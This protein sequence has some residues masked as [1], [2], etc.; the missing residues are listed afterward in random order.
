MQLDPIWLGPQL[1]GNGAPY[2]HL[3]HPN[4]MHELYSELDRARRFRVTGAERHWGEQAG[5]ASN[6]LV[7][8]PPQAHE[9]WGQSCLFQASLAMTWAAATSLHWLGVAEKCQVQFRTVLWLMSTGRYTFFA[10]LA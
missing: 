8:W 10:G 3:H 6:A 1:R 5:H 2:M 7:V 4:K 9:P